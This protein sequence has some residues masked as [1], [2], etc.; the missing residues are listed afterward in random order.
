MEEDMNA[1][2]T[3]PTEDIIYV[4]TKKEVTF[5][6]NSDKGCRWLQKNTSNVPHTIQ[7]E[8]LDDF[9][10]VLVEHEITYERTY[11]VPEL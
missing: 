2:Y 9:L 3:R 4:E 8:H 1:Y 10:E 7:R 5:F 6:G 11:T